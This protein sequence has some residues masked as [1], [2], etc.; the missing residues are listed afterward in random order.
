MLGSMLEHSSYERPRPLA[1]HTVSSRTAAREPL[2][3]RLYRNQLGIILAVV[4][5]VAA[6]V[7]LL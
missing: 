5:T 3:E 6:A 4:L 2:L 1:D 7:V